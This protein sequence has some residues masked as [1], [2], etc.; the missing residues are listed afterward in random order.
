MSAITSFQEK[1]ELFTRS[2]TPT[3]NVSHLRKQF[4]QNFPADYSFKQEEIDA[5][6]S[7]V[8]SHITTEKTAKL[9]SLSIST[10][11]IADIFKLIEKD[12]DEIPEPLCAYIALRVCS[13]ERLD[14]S[15][16]LSKMESA[17]IDDAYLRYKFAVLAAKRNVAD[18]ASQVA[19]FR[20]KESLLMRRLAEV[21]LYFDADAFFS[22]LNEFACEENEVREEFY[23]RGLV[24]SMDVVEK[25]LEDHVFLPS[26]ENFPTQVLEWIYEQFSFGRTMIQEAIQQYAH[27][28]P[29]AKS[30][31]SFSDFPEFI[32]LMQ[33]VE[34]I[35]IQQKDRGE[36]LSKSA[37]PMTEASVFALFVQ[38]SGAPQYVLPEMGFT[39]VKIFSTLPENEQQAFLAILL[40]LKSFPDPQLVIQNDQAVLFLK[41]IH[42]FHDPAVRFAAVALAL[43]GTKK[44][45]D[46]TTQLSHPKAQLIP[47]A[48][49]PKIY[50]LLL[51][52]CNSLVQGVDLTFLQ[53][54]WKDIYF[55]K[56]FVRFLTELFFAE[57]LTDSERQQ[58]LLKFLKF[59]DLQTPEALMDLS[60]CL[61]RRLTRE[62]KQGHTPR[63]ILLEKKFTFVDRLGELY[64]YSLDPNLFAKLE[65]T[66]EISYYA[67][68]LERLPEGEKKDMVT[69]FFNFLQWTADGTMQKARYSTPELKDLFSSYPLKQE[70][71]EKRSESTVSAILSQFPTL[72]AENETFHLQDEF[73][74][75]FDHKHLLQEEYD[76]FYQYAFQGV[77]QAPEL[78][79]KTFGKYKN[80]SP[81]EQKKAISH[82]FSLLFAA[83]D[84]KEQIRYLAQLRKL[85]P[86]TDDFSVDMS[87]RLCK[88]NFRSRLSS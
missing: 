66:T 54:K 45:I 71:W 26:L 14:T 84:P 27:P 39:P 70:V 60:L 83:T 50:S 22:E 35:E 16:I 56:S 37:V 73:K 33:E 40:L 82:L 75:S 76:A 79:G 52:A 86:T 15:N 31:K 46:L 81:E 4:S 41:E 68:S 38:K 80:G 8:K 21:A 51:C 49:Y 85:L 11:L 59:K 34:R 5:F 64:G 23:L 28:T 43:I 32:P 30:S 7:H 62:L 42:S 17:N 88:S 12:P 53:K 10:A 67:Q 44:G 63:Q 48:E 18:F 74:K 19:D 58:I 36:D 78:E 55:R 2:I 65:Y 25:L 6:V 77:L 24:R 1:I 29:K 57:K 69:C 9:F 61:S 72:N 87:S 20:L 13:E 3:A 47:T